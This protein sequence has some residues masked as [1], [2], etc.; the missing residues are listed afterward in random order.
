MYR[1]GD[2][3]HFKTIVRSE[4]PSGYTLPQE[5]ELRLELRD[6]RTYQP[7]WQ[8]TVTLSDM[9]TA[10]WDYVIPAD[11]NLG[12]YYLSMQ[13]GERYVE[14][15]RFSVQDYKKPEYA[16]KVIAQTPRVLQGQPIKATIDARY[17]FGEPVANAKVKWVVHTSTYWPIGTLRVRLRHGT[18]A[19][20]RG[21][22]E[23]GPGDTYGG[24]QETENSGTLDADGKLQITIPTRVNDKT[25]QDLTYRIEA[26]V[27]DAGNREISGHGFALATYGSFY[28]TAQPNSYVYTK[29]G[30]AIINVT[31][32]DY[33]KK[34]I[35]TA[36]RAEISRWNWQ[37]RSGELV[38]TSQGQTDAERQ[39][40][41]AIH[42]SGRGRIPRSRQRRHSRESR[43]GRH[44]L[45]VGSG[46]KPV[47]ERHH[48][49][50]HSDRRRQEVVRAGRH[51]ARA[52]RH[53]QGAGFR[54]GHRRGQRTLLRAGDQEQRRQHH[55][56]CSH[57][58]G[59]RAQ[60]L[61]VGGLHSRQQAVPGQQEPLGAADA[62]RTEGRS[63]A[64]EAA[65][66]AGTARRLH[67]QGHRLQR[68][69]RRRPSSVSAWWTKP[70]TPS[71][72]RPSAT[73]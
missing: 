73:S 61:R 19:I 25:K 21:D 64:V 48:A 32:Q 62:A 31:A 57:P 53:R 28:L 17:Y 40:A 38:S 55:R 23:Q 42:H 60:L 18:K 37:K 39:G 9:G 59:V 35:A 46:R 41:G 49:G 11:A 5:R 52:D 33:D 14:G 34:P 54:A 45:P 15:T 29:G 68:Q 16:V 1:P 3:V 50:A 69:A 65:V 2:T 67:H 26:R 24:E 66:S 51:R 27:T 7:I 47:V 44:R 20:R 4:N 63:A 10:H 71:S 6:P 36:F 58:A 43:G 56:R 70:S 8:Q 30:T 72:P 22:E 12:F 13:S